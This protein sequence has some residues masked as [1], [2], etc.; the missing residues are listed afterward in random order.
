MILLNCLLIIR[1][2]KKKEKKIIE[3]YPLFLCS[4]LMKL[5]F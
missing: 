1:K 3:A 2:G 4:N 5:D